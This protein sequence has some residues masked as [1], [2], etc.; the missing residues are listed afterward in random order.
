MIHAFTHVRLS[1]HFETDSL[2]ECVCLTV[3]FAGVWSQ[4]RPVFSQSFT[5]EPQNTLLDLSENSQQLVLNCSVENLG[6]GQYV[7]WQVLNQSNQQY[8]ALSV[9]G[10]LVST[11]RA[12]IGSEVAI[13]GEYNLVIQNPGLQTPTTYRCAVGAGAQT[14]LTR[15][16]EVIILG[17]HT[18]I[19]RA[20][21]S[22]I[23]SKDIRFVSICHASHRAFIRFFCIFRPD[24]RVYNVGS[25][26]RCNR[27]LSFTNSPFSE[28][29]PTCGSNFTGREVS[30]GD[31][32]GVWCEITYR[33]RW[34]PGMRWERPAQPFRDIFDT[35]N[36][37]LN[38]MTVR[39]ELTY[40]APVSE[41]EGEL[42][43]VTWL[44]SA[45]DNSGNNSHRAATNRLPLNTGQCTINFTINRKKITFLE[46]F[47]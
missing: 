7:A 27:L 10:A 41:D 12:T 9:N 18:N 33:G 13:E 44:G 46:S 39:H 37:G 1:K 22:R 34:M 47:G 42:N 5:V 38:G 35:T 30:G 25:L 11:A 36:T 31:V 8:V 21:T 43:C 3:C 45:I 32:L 14:L 26:T 29:G 24:Q 19:C 20:L 40:T 17:N 2:F 6:S 28:G 16:A 15:S 4:V 23:K